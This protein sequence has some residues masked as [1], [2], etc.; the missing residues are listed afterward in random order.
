VEDAYETVRKAVLDVV[1]EGG[2]VMHFGQKS[3]ALLA[4]VDGDGELLST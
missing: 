2:M 1:H 4:S 3:E